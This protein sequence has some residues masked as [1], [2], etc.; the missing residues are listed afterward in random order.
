[1]KEKKRTPRNLKGRKN[2]RNEIIRKKNTAMDSK[3]KEQ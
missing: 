1:V 2:S 3:E